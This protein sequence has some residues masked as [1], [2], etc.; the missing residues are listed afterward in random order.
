MY[1]SGKK[2]IVEKLPMLPTGLHYTHINEIESNAVVMKSSILTMWHDRLGHPGSS[3]MRRII[4]NMH[5]HPLKGHKIPQ[6][7]IFP[8]KACSLGK[9]IKTITGKG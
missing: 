9:L 5:G 6:G 2:Y 4:E 7:N 1:R 3:M 8:C